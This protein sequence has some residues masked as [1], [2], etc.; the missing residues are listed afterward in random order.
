MLAC[1]YVCMYVVLPPPFYATCTNANLGTFSLFHLLWLAVLKRGDKFFI[2]L[3]MFLPVHN[4][5][6]PVF[7]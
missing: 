5:L 7:V 4:I 3:L 6:I 2:Y 1:T